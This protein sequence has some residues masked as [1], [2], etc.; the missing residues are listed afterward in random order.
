MFGNIKDYKLILYGIFTYGVFAITLMNA[1]AKSSNLLQ[2]LLQLFS[3]D[4][5]LV[6]YVDGG[7]PSYNISFLITLNFILYNSYVF[8]N[9]IL[10]KWLLFGE[11]RLI[12]TENINTRFVSTVINDIVMFTF[13]MKTHSLDKD[14]ILGN[15]DL[16]IIKSK[17]NFTL[18]IAIYIVISLSVRIIHWI[19][20]D[21]LEMIYSRLTNARGADDNS[22]YN[23]E[24]LTGDSLEE[25]KRQLKIGNIYFVMNFYRSRYFLILLI[26]TL[27]SLKSAWEFNKPRSKISDASSGID[28]LAF[29][30][31][32]FFTLLTIKT[33][34]TWCFS[35][36]N[37]LDAYK[38]KCQQDSI[39][40]KLRESMRQINENTVSDEEGSDSSL[41]SNISNEEDE[42]LDS[43]DEGIFGYND[44]FEAKYRIELMISLVTNVL[45][46]GARLVIACTYSKFSTL[47]T[48]ISNQT[49]S[50]V[51]SAFSLV[52]NLMNIYDKYEQLQ[53][54]PSPTESEC[55]EDDTCIICMDSLYPTKYQLKVAMNKHRV[56]ME[57][58]IIQDA[59]I[60]Y[61]PK[62]LPCGHFLHLYCLK[63]WFERSKNCPMCRMD[64]FDAETGKIRRQVFYKNRIKTVDEMNSNSGNIEEP[65][66]IPLVT[67][68]SVENENFTS[69]NAQNESPLRSSNAENDYF[70]PNVEPDEI[71]EIDDSDSSFEYK[72]FFDQRKG[73]QYRMLH[74]SKSKIPVYDVDGD[75]L[76]IAMYKGYTKDSLISLKHNMKTSGEFE[77]VDNEDSDTKHIKIEISTTGFIPI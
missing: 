22:N 28:I 34:S 77:K 75:E 4:F 60:K 7:P 8:V 63:T 25:D 69:E 23:E 33:V 76:T 55:K 29:A 47:S 13:L 12:E 58:N 62:T 70:N 49:I 61:N 26:L 35:V 15:I 16:F 3:S 21:R 41:E 9:I 52:Q 39:V 20:L 6:G 54:L 1:L 30:F 14:D 32:I 48:L 46:I 67:G 19:N 56:A 42:Y 45:N 2:L 11:L 10:I 50:E 44:T 36:V 43:D 73:M 40:L 68:Q 27:G 5:N 24:V 57:D 72:D 37:L 31:R 66:L 53:D 18:N 38:S 64:I 51:Y 65:G 71:Q 59:L 17:S 74:F